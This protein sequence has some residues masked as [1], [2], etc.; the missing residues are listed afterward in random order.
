MI[1]EHHVDIQVLCPMNRG[2]FGARALNLELQRALNP[3]GESR[4]ERFGWSFGPGDKVMQVVN[5]YDR[6][7]Y[8]GDLGVVRRIDQEESALIVQFDG[9]EVGYDFGELDELVLAYA[10]TIHKSQGS[11][12]PA[13]DRGQERRITTALVKAAQMA[14]LIGI[15]RVA[16]HS[17]SRRSERATPRQDGALC[18][19][20]RYGPRIKP[21]SNRSR[22]EA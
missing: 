16:S 5:D 10:T 21:R 15:A 11:E 22:C 20:G 18:F 2:A 8:N 13:G 6:D 1:A 17:R 14:R 7:V 3:P 19:P 9:R 4:V 12:Y